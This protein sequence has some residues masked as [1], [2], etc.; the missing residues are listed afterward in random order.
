MTDRHTEGFESLDKLFK[1]MGAAASGKVLRQS[2]TYAV[3]PVVQQARKTAPVGSKEHRTYKGRLV[4]PGFLSRNI[5]KK[6]FL[7]RSKS[8]ASVT[9]SMV[10]EAW[11]GKLFS[12][13]VK[14]DRAFPHNDFLE[15]A[16]DSKKEQMLTRFYDKLGKS[17][18]KAFAKTRGKK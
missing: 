5:G 17:I 7:S 2:V 18:D 6:S 13:A 11:Y 8:F 1:E 4:F 14:K 3:T 12:S 9:V 15:Q 10:G 16:F